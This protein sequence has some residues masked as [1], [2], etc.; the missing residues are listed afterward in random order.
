MA[1]APKGKER[2]CWVCGTSIG[3]VEDRFYDRRDSC[4]SR[5]CQ[6]EERDAYRAERDE[7]HEQLD[8][9]RGWDR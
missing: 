9:D 3:Y 4:G 1:D 6:R 7:A 8:R 2:F 5:E